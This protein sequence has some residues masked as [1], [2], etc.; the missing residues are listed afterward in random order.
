MNK[1]HKLVLFLFLSTFI[2][3][4]QNKHNQVDTNG[5]RHGIWKKLY[6]NG[7]VRY[8]GEFNHGKEVGTF[9]FYAITGEKKPIVVKIFQA[10]KSLTAVEFFSKKGVPESK[11]NMQGK[12]RIGEWIYYFND[13]KTIL[14]KENYIDG[15]LDGKF[16]VFYK[17]GKLT[18]LAHYQKGKLNGKRIRYS[19]TGKETEN[20]TYKT[21][22]MHGPAIIYDEKGEVYAKGSYIE[23][24]KSG[25]WEFNMDGEM[26]KVEADKI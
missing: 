12:N 4:A 6:R 11:G 10:N 26:V 13:G 8:T 20:I 24:I 22:V 9:N 17:N 25:V 14:S 3:F 15:L 23:G 7:N 19:D 2:T 21:G 18:E 5:K 16:Q 1:K